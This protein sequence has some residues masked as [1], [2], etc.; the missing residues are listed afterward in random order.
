MVPV[1]EKSMTKYLAPLYRTPARMPWRRP[2][3]RISEA[4]VKTC[5]MG[6]DL[7]VSPAWMVLAG[8]SEPR[9]QEDRCGLRFGPNMLDLPKLITLLL[10]W[11]RK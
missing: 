2:Y 7:E 4:L 5:S 1:V 6:L 8:G 10:E 9:R 3:R 11:G